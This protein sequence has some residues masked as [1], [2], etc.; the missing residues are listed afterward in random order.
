MSTSKRATKLTKAHKVLQKHYEPRAV[1]ERPVLEQLLYACCLEFASP[2]DADEAFAKL[3]QTYYDWN[4]VRVTTVSELCEVLSRLPKPRGTASHLKRTLHSVFE[5]YYSFDLEPLKK[6]NIGKAVQQL[7][8]LD[9]ISKFAM[10]FV[11]QNGLCGHAIA[12][13]AEALEAL[14]VLG[15]ISDAEAAD[16]RVPGLERAIPKN[17]GPEFR[18]LLH[19]LAVEYGAAPFSPRVRSIMLEI[20]P[21]AKQRFPKR[22]SKKTDKSSADKSSAD[23]GGKKKNTARKKKDT[24][25]TKTDEKKTDGKTEGGK[26]KKADIQQLS[27]RKPR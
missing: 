6:E 7:E 19:Q 27:K 17:K 16:K 26:Q 20:A 8:K 2:E 13:N 10:A 15:I 12:V 23:K 24:E 11:I 21:D 14:R 1:A 18:A 9:G 25:T 5:Q 22:S 4:E 3:Q